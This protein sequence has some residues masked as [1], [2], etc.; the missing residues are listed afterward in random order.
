M[1]RYSVSMIFER[2]V[3]NH[4]SS[5]TIL[6]KDQTSLNVRIVYAKTEEEAFGIAYKDA[7][8]SLNGY[9]LSNRVVVEI[10]KPVKTKIVP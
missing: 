1:K 3:Y 10:L 5:G 9:V 4:T 7:K 6:Q 8:K 2:Y